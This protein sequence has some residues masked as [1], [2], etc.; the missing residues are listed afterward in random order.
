[1]ANKK[2]ECT[3]KDFEKWIIPFIYSPKDEFS[4][5]PTNMIQSF[6]RKTAYE[7][8]KRTG[9]LR[10]TLYFHLDC[11]VCDYNIGCIGDDI[12]SYKKV[13]VNGNLLTDNDYEVRD[14]VL[15]LEFK[16]TSDVYE[17]ISVEYSYAP[18]EDLA[19]EVPQ[20]FCTRYREGIIA[21]V[22]SQLFCMP[23]MDWYS[24]SASEKFKKDY[25]AQISMA[26]VDIRKRKSSRRKTIYDMET[27][28][29]R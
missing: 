23:H 5:P 2:C 11:G 25:E 28:F 27:R 21:G 26:K 3:W 15:Y 24:Q 4:R 8:A 16:P 29:I 17:G 10:R 12:F 7:F 13:T 6:I 1:M 19:C 22:L 9:V 20:E 18:C 14:D